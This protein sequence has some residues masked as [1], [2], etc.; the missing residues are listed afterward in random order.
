[1]AEL[2]S[3]DQFPYQGYPQLIISAMLLLS[4]FTTDTTI[5]ILSA[6]TIRDIRIRG[7]FMTIRI[8]RD[9]RG[10]YPRIVTCYC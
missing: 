1:M 9:I 2:K 8:T 7:N 6:D 5:R 4:M 10:Y 3:V